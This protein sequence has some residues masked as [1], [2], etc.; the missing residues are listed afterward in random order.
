[1]GV[2]T[3][4]IIMKRIFLLFTLASTIVSFGQSEPKIR[5]I[6]SLITYFAANDKFMGS[7]TI[8]EKDK[9]VFE[10]AYGYADAEN[11]IPANE[12]T[13]YK[14][15]SITKMFTSA[16]IFQLIEDKKLT[17]ETKLSEYYPKV[18]NA[19]TITI[20]QLLGHQTGIYNFTDA[21]DFESYIVTP[22][23]KKQMVARIEGFDSVF[24]P[25][26]KAEYSNSNYMLLGYIIQDITKK[27]YKEN[28][29]E[30]IVKKLGLKN[31]AYYGKINTQKNEAYSYM[32][33]NGEWEKYDEWHE[34]ATFAAGGLQSTTTDLTKF[35][36]ALFDG[37]II[38]K[39]SLDEMIKIASGYGK[40]IF[41][42]PFGERRFYGH[43]GGIEG[44]HSSI[45][46]YPKDEMS[47][48]LI[49]NGDNYDTNEIMIGILSIYYKIPYPFPNLKTV[50]VAPEILK[51]YEGEYS[52]NTHPLKIVIKY[53][54]GKLMAQATGQGAFPLNP[55]SETEFNFDPAGITVKFKKDA[56]TILQGSHVDEFTRE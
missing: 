43:T 39:E 51:S 22:Q 16:I 36:K 9:V 44:F 11:K 4:I 48:A 46:Y 29:N 35:V 28:V 42:F 49:A 20:A 31:T 54:Q 47:V 55:L 30:R 33:I 32:Y 7:I 1:M 15:G 13:K 17:L 8:R 56:F 27:S 45:G 25:G 40:G 23:T 37:K 14:I 5:K 10:K 3:I 53:H 18:K 34:S 19:D 52:S 2:S 26:T 24:E 12:Q 38:K 50:D 21:D 41:A 6:D